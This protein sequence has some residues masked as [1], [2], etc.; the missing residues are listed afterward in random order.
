MISLCGNVVDP[1][2]IGRKVMKTLSA[3]LTFQAGFPGFGVG[4]CGE[5]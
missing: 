4:P 3:A 2:G 1:R 5:P